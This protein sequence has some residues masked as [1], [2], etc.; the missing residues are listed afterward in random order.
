[1]LVTDNVFVPVLNVKLPL[2][3]NN[4]LMPA[5]VTLPNVNVLSV[6]L[7]NVTLA[8]VAT[9]CGIDITLLASTLMF[10]PTCT[11]PSSTLDVWG[12]KYDID[13]SLC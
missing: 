9:L 1:M 12:N 10:A 8:V 6:I 7:P 5:N 11:T 3:V 4:P 2:S 13:F